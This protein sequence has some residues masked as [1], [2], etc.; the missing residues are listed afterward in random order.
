MFYFIHYF[1]QIKIY[2][3]RRAP[4][5]VLLIYWRKKIGKIDPGDLVHEFCVMQIGL[6]KKEERN[7]L[8]GICFWQ[9]WWETIFV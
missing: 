5:W 2:A 6:E 9:T 4:K 1:E 8:E 3:L 7:L